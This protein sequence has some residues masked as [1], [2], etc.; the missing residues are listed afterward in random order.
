MAGY[1]VANIEVNDPETFAKYREQV[2]PLIAKFGGRYLI[3]GGELE[4]VEG[5]MPF[6][7]VVVLEFPSVAEAKRFYHSAEYTP[8]LKLR[9]DS[10][11][12]DV[13]LVD[14]YAG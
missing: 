7:R 11:N 4:Q 13:A 9:T 5:S 3:R 8:L 1:L 2:A 6:K 14:G 10:C 12:S